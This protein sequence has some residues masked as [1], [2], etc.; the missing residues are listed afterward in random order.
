VNADRALYGPNPRSYGHT[1]YGGSFGFAD[2]DARLAVGYAMNRM[3]AT[4]AGEPRGAA[5]VEAVYA[6]LARA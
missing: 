5:L 3:A 4:L 1:G 6:S 2:P